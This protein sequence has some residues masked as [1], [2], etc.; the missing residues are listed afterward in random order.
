MKRWYSLILSFTLII[1][2]QPTNVVDDALSR[3]QISN[4]L[5]ET[6]LS[7]NRSKDNTIHSAESSF[8]NVID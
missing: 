4:N 5:T 7:D 6:D 1:K 3:I 8:E 2:Y